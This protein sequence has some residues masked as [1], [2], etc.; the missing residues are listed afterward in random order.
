MEDAAGGA[1]DAAAAEPGGGVTCRGDVGLLDF[2]GDCASGAPGLVG[3][4]GRA[5]V[6]FPTVDTG[7]AIGAKLAGPGEDGTAEPDPI[8]APVDWVLVSAADG[9]GAAAIEFVLLASVA[10][11]GATR[12]EASVLLP[13]EK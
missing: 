6:G 5:L 8:E 3:G 10:A 9:I 2:M 13:I 7:E 12:D 11:D 4:V 1:Y